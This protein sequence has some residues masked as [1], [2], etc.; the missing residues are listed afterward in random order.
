MI[1][2][3]L[4]LYFILITIK[5][6]ANIVTAAVEEWAHLYSCKMGTPELNVF[7]AKECKVRFVPPFQVQSF[8]SQRLNPSHVKS[9][10]LKRLWGFKSISRIRWTTKCSK[11]LLSK[12]LTLSGNIISKL[13]SK[14]KIKSIFELCINCFRSGG[15]LVSSETGA[16]KVQ[17]LKSHLNPQMQTCD[18]TSSLVETI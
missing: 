12:S 3:I 14:K 11:P 7:W 1:K 6:L 10:V 5:L 9:S 18:A 8:N 13:Q 17:R 2:T 15:D 16:N 4:L